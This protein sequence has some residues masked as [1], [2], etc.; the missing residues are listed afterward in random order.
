VFGK[1]RRHSA[2]KE[3][4]KEEAVKL[5]KYYNVDTSGA[6]EVKYVEAVRMSKTR[7]W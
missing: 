4:K 3:G 1:F 7:H 2:I 5:I 6:Q